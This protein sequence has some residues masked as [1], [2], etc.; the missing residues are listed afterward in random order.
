MKTIYALKDTAVQAFNTPMFM[1]SQ[2]E[3]LRALQDE[4]NT[5]KT[6]SALAAHPEDYELYRLGEY[7]EDTGAITPEQP[8]VLIA[9]AK[10]LLIPI[11]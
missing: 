4:V 7:N 5:D 3:M 10:D 6:K 2:G 11:N 9:R 8:A 1:R